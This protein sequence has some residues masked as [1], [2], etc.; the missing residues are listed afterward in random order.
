MLP[1]SS[2]YS[3]A[4]LGKYIFAASYIVFHADSVILYKS[5]DGGK[6]WSESDSGMAPIKYGFPPGVFVANGLVYCARHDSIG[7]Y[8]SADSG[9]HWV[10][11]NNGL[12]PYWT[13]PVIT[14]AG[15]YVFIGQYYDSL[16]CSSDSGA[17]WN[18]VQSFPPND[19]VGALQARD[20]I[21]YIGTRDG[22]FSTSDYGKNLNYASNGL[23]DYGGLALYTRD[24]VVMAASQIFSTCYHT[25][26]RSV[27]F[28]STDNG[29]TFLP[30]TN[31]ISYATLTAFISDGSTIFAGS[32]NGIYISTDDGLHWKISDSSLDI[33]DLVT[34]NS[35]VF[36]EFV[37][38][39]EEYGIIRSTDNGA[40]WTVADSS[41][42]TSIYF[43]HLAVCNGNVFV[44]TNDSEGVYRTMNN[45]VNWTITDSGLPQYIG[46]GDSA[47]TS[48]G[49]L[50]DTLYAII[51]NNSF[52][53][54][55]NNGD[56]WEPVSVSGLP[57]SATI[58]TLLIHGD[59]MFAGT[60][61]GIYFST[62]RG[63][64]WYSSNDGF[65]AGVVINILSADYKYLYAGTYSNGIYRRPLSDFGIN[66]VDEKSAA[67]PAQLALSQNYP[68]PFNGMT[69]VE[70]KIPNEEPVTLTVYNSLG[71]EIATLAAGEQSA[72]AH[73][74]TFNGDE[75]QNG[76]YFYRLTAGNSVRSGKMAVMK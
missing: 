48:F 65:P 58:R 27:M 61:S 13:S 53:R 66:A 70:Y 18:A 6:T 34:N 32:N 75:W 31:G 36:A 22:I 19:C 30:D 12:P 17:T 67:L 69:N 23:S 43:G 50:D 42:P 24:S 52:Y 55:T 8:M 29:N 62:N 37:N 59:N 10:P 40:S 11:R 74:V 44:S 68:N 76:I 1:Y 63:T 35:D 46:G 9:R 64:N 26:V 51:G 4:T 56:L 14:I 25:S 39:I 7:L 72:G 73:T 20:S 54:T 33:T 41:V 60:D 3:I 38:P 5:S 16:Y 15:K 57:T 28:R 49:V 47:V 45:G 2:I 71:E 21:L